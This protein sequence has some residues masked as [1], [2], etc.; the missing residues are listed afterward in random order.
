MGAAGVVDGLGRSGD[1]GPGRVG[2]ERNMPDGPEK[3]LP[4]RGVQ[5]L[6]V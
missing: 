3:H 2:G 5:V 6:P 1:G 4:F